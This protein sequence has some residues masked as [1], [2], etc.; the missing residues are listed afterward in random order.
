MIR[1]RNIY[2]IKKDV[3][4]D[5]EGTSRCNSNFLVLLE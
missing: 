5:Q 3:F 2:M 1:A 4:L